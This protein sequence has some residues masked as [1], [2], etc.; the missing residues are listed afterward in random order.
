MLAQSSFLFYN[1]AA[2]SGKT[3]TLSKT[4]LKKLFESRDQRPFRKLLAITFTNKAVAEMKDRI[5][6]SLWYFSDPSLKKDSTKEQLLKDL[7]E[8]LNQS[9][10]L[11]R[12]K[13]Q[14]ILGEIL[15]NYSNFELTTID[16]F[17]HRII[18]SFALDLDLNPGFEVTL[19]PEE[20]LKEAIELLIE[21]VEKASAIEEILLQLI[22]EKIA[23]GK[24]WDIGYT[25][26]NASKDV[27]LKEGNT[28]IFEKNP[29]NQSEIQPLRKG[30]SSK[31]ETHK[32][33]VQEK[34]LELLELILNDQEGE[35]YKKTIIDHL[36]TMVE[37]MLEATKLYNDTNT[38]AL[39]N[40]SA[41]LKNKAFDAQVLQTLEI[42]Y[43]NLQ[44]KLFELK[45]LQLIDAQVGPYALLKEISELYQSV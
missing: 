10:S 36:K 20:N 41:T 42:E 16:T 28:A 25:L 2:G 12:K 31:I 18:R 33:A 9:E 35:P 5:L 39:N 1:A 27:L 38:K 23:E 13:S 44:N 40:G 30:L 43:P 15:H 3:Y 45:R 37:G 11:I 7:S 34:A 6:Q 4:Y 19:D 21:G 14:S 26:L 29:I 22:R 32:K 17:T 8:E 24:S